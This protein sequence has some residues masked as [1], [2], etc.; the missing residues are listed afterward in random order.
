MRAIVITE[1][2]GPEV[3]VAGERPVPEPGPGEVLIDIAAAGVNF[4]DVYF[5][6]GAYRQELPYIPG[7]EA[8]GTVAAVGDGVTEFSAGDRVAWANVQGAYAEQA[9]VPADR[10]V[11]V[12]DG[13][14]LEDAAASLL[15]GMTAHYLTRST[16]PIQEGDT[17]LVH[18]AAGGMGL[19]LTQAAKA[20]GARVIGTAS[21]PEKEKLAKDAGADVT[22]GYDGFPE[23]VRELTGGEGVAAVYDGVGAPTFDGSLASLRRRGV[24][25]LYGAAGGPVPPFDPQRLNAAGSVYLARPSLAHFTEVREELLERAADVYGWV[26]SGALRVHVGRRHDLAEAAT[27]HADLEARRSTGKLL[28]L[29]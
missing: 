8:A 9:A 16:Y 18:A 28:L 20:L 4:I 10:V 3:L 5:R 13:V 6:T 19:L 2:G 1:N 7:V 21:T 17:V 14:T 29:P 26:G 25:A 24:L 11:P 22:M 15:Q 23:R 27:A 12:P